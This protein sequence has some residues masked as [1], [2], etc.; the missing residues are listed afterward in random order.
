MNE[1]ITVIIKTFRRY[2]CLLQIV[3]SIRKFYPTVTIIIADDRKDSQKKKFHSILFE[4]PLPW[5]HLNPC[6]TLTVIFHLA[7]FHLNF[8]SISPHFDLNL[9]S[10]LPRSQR[11]FTSNLPQSY[12]NFTS[13]S[14][15]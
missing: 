13:I 8:T 1:R 2:N 12:L 15:F 6:F 10:I 5:V 14:P 3:N 4:E 11:I 9:T 7:Q